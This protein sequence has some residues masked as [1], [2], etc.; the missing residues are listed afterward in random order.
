[1][2]CSAVGNFLAFFLVF[3]TSLGCGNSR[4]SRLALCVE[5]LLARRIVLAQMKYKAI[6]RVT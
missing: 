4:G 6:K 1:M 5:T 2:L 3:A